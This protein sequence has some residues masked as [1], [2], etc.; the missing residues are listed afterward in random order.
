MA[1]PQSWAHLRPP[2]VVLYSATLPHSW[3]LLITLY[4]VL[5][6]AVAPQSWMHPCSLYVGLHSSIPRAGRIPTF[7]IWCNTQ[8]LRPRADHITPCHIGCYTGPF[9]TC[10]PSHGTLYS[11]LPQPPHP[12]AG[13]TSTRPP[14]MVLHSAIPHPRAG[15]ISPLCYMWLF[16]P[17]AGCIS[18]L[19]PPPPPI[20]PPLQGT[21]RILSERRSEQRRLLS[22]IGSAALLDSDLLKLNQLKVRGGGGSVGLGTPSWP[23]ASQSDQFPLPSLPVPQEEAAVWAQPHPRVGAVRH[24]AHRRRRDGH[25]VCGAEHPAGEEPLCPRAS[26]ILAIC[27]AV[28]CGRFPAVPPRSQPH[29]SCH[30]GC[31]MWL[32]SRCST[33]EPATSQLLRVAGFW[34][35]CHRA[36]C[37][38][39]VLHGCFLAAPPESQLHPSYNRHCMWLFSDAPLQSWPHLGRPHSCSPAAPAQSLPHHK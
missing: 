19:T 33:P 1:V 12:R 31:S 17:R 21:N 25:R 30:H 15:C 26:R 28:M 20:Y 37:I 10:P 16:L 13:C 11:A 8:L 24:G 27:A 4:M 32:V 34:L 39:A 9:S 3:V 5:Y 38:S 29:P 35:L 22:A 23:S 6:L 14:H 2:Y 36:S 7:S 18:A